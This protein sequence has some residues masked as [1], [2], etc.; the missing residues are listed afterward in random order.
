M[1][2]ALLRQQ[3]PFDAQKWLILGALNAVVGVAMF[4]F[5]DKLKANA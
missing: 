4:L 1:Q 2:R 3:V 5:L